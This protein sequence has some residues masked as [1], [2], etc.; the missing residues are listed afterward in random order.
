MAMK[1]DPSV[2]WAGPTRPYDLIKEL[3]AAVVVIGLLAA[4]L[5][6]LFSSPDEKAVTLKSWA[7]TNPVDFVQTATGE[8]AGTTTSASYGPPYN[9][10]GKG[11]HFGILKMQD[12]AGVRIPINP[13]QSFVIE[14]LTTYNDVAAQDAVKVWNAADPSAQTAWANGYADALSKAKDAT[15]VADSHNSYG[16]VPTLVTSL[17]NMAKGGALDGALLT[18]D[19]TLPTNFTKPLLFLAD[20]EGYF[21]AKAEEQH[22][23]GEQWGVMNE[24][25]SWPGQSW[26]W[27]FSFWYQIDPFKSSDN[28]DTIIMLLMGLCTLLLALVPV[29]PGIRKIPYKI[30]LHRL[31]WKDWYSK[32]L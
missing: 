1:V 7:Q 9:N 19:S 4:G 24:T 18:S 10:A 32:K 27:L 20:S 6:F 28:A 12:W 31:I 11:Q 14:P 25:G 5:A 17:L 29:L 30:P 3:V 23:G 16:P 22:L 21:A 15:S 2:K 13:A 8:L 26:L